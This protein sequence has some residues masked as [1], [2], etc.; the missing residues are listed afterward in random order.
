MWRRRLG[1]S[2]S[3]TKPSHMDSRYGPAWTRIV[4][5]RSERELQLDIVQELDAMSC[6]PDTR[7]SSP[8]PTERCIQV[9]CEQSWIAS[10]AVSGP[11]C[12]WNSLAVRI[13]IVVRQYN[14]E[15]TSRFWTGKIWKMW[16]RTG[17]QLHRKW[18]F[19]KINFYTLKGI[20]WKP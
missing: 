15:M 5:C 3:K 11:K 18:R 8:Y 19:F 17:A 1:E 16:R 10:A 12:G 14:D 9:R 4:S 20:K 7:S 6:L 2:P 13:D